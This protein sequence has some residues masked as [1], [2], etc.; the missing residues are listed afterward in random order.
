MC[1]RFA[2]TAA[3]KLIQEYYSLPNINF[4]WEPKYNIAPSQQVPV[5]IEWKDKRSLQLQ[6]WGFIPSWN[7]NPKPKITPANAR[8]ETIMTNKL[9]NNAIRDKRCIIPVT[10][11]FE[12]VTENAI[13]QP[14]YISHPE[15]IPLSMAGI[16]S[17]C[18]IEGNEINTF[19]IITTE[20]NASVVNI[21]HRMPLLISTEYI[22][23]WLF[24]NPKFNIESIAEKQKSL[25]LN[26]W[27]VTTRMNNP[28]Y[29]D[30]TCI[31]KC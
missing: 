20:A 26:T 22:D 29:A 15:N 5:I 11:Y 3:P 1:G 18:K 30:P 16:W 19:A 7:S 28:R 8:L 17:T 12:W 6:K 13:K 23:E 2:S 24:A 25:L 31:V 4:T 14:Y 9:F 27:P 21:H 10:G